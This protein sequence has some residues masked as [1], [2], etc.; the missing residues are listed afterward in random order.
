MVLGVHASGVRAPI[1]RADMT[2]VVLTRRRQRPLGRALCSLAR[3][4]GVALDVLVIVDDCELTVDYLVHLPPAFGAIRSL[5]VVHDTREPGEAS[6]PGRV[7]RLRQW[8]VGL[9]TSTW[10]TFLDDDNVVEPD[11]CLSLLRCAMDGDASAAHSWRS[12]WSHDGQPFRLDGHHPWCRDRARAR[13]IFDRY[14]AAG[15]YRRHSHIV[16]DQVVPRRRH[17]SMVDTSEW[18]FDAAFLR[19]FD[20]CQDYT[21]DDW[22]DARTEDNKLLDEIVDLGH[23]VP[24]T[25]RPTLRYFLGGYSNDPTHEAAAQAGWLS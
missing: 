18:I 25:H 3:Q 5:H 19:R 17:L 8:A 4:R 11:H 15:I 9:V 7:A 14:E 20:W 12:L 21:V 13:D 2:V 6:G 1:C 23:A 16:K 24:S 10:L 22:E